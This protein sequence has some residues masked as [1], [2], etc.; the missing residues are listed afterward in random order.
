MSTEEQATKEP[1]PSLLKRQIGGGGKAKDTAPKTGKFNIPPRPQVN[2]MPPEILEGR[3]LAILK[4]RLVWAIAALLLVVLLA[5]GLA[6]DNLA[7]RDNTLLPMVWLHA[8]AP[9]VICAWL[10]YWPPRFRP[11]RQSA[12][13]A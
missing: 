3:H 10:L 2:L 7:A 8:V 1:K 13:T 5:F 6:M 12:A 4:R 11:L 9:G